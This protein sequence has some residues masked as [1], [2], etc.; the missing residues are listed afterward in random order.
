M[1]QQLDKT[2]LACE[3]ILATL[4]NHEQRLR[5]MGVR[6]LGLFG[7]HRTGVAR[8]DS[9]LDFLVVLERPSFNDYMEVK[10]YLE[11]LF[12]REVDLVLAE[13]LKPRLRAQILSEVIY[14]AGLSPVSR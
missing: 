2:T 7:S 12:D 13:S 1:A 3:A 6:T 9:D 4:T 8:P 11:R 5:E 10:W 14:A